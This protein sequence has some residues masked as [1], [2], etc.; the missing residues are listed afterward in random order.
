MG[1]VATLVI[2]QSAQSLTLAAWLGFAAGAFA[3]VAAAAYFDDVTITDLAEPAPGIV[4]LTTHA[5][6]NGVTADWAVA[7]G[8]GGVRAASWTATAFAQPPF[9]PQPQG[10]T[11]LPGFA[12]TYSSLPDGSL[13]MN[14]P[15]L[16]AF[17]AQP[18]IYTEGETSDEFLIRV[19]IGDAT[20]APDIGED[21]GVDRVDFY[22]W[23][24]DITLDNYEQM[25]RWGLGKG[26][27]S[28]IGYVY[29]DS[30]LSAACIA[31]VLISETF[32]IHISSNVVL[33]LEQ[34]GYHYP[35]E[36]DAFNNVIG[37]ELFHNFQMAY[38][39][40]EQTGRNPHFSYVEGT[41]R[42]QETLHSY[43]A[44]SHQ[45]QSLV[46][47]RN[48][49]GCPGWLGSNANQAFANG[50]FEGHSYDACYFWMT[51]FDTHG[52]EGLVRLVEAIHD[53]VGESSGAPQIFPAIEDATGGTLA[54]DLAIFA[55]NAITKRGYVWPAGDDGEELD[56]ARFLPTLGPQRLDVG[57]S[58][59]ATL[60]NGGLMAAEVRNAGV[61]GLD[62]P[63]AVVL[64]LVTD[65]GEETVHERIEPGLIEAPE[66]GER[67][68]VVAVHPAV[69]QAAVTLTLTAA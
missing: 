15:M 32:N 7:V 58:R 62:A 61:L 12:R 37:H 20:I 54:D 33:I 9:D 47:A 13:R 2:S 43:S 57:D 63:E 17:D 48:I 3:G 68:W 26:W 39:K 21:T 56:W 6:T 28:D 29:V 18:S 53:H 40:P 16:P 1:V 22:R 59:S 11:A 65:D 8:A 5:R 50:L 19:S 36:R 45:P 30:A 25:H 67:Q 23:V 34:L 31:C 27:T 51:W 69:G 35:D 55:G 38:W 49:N 10:L 66:P 41:A 44:V 42:F 46:Y 64:Y 14:Q 4:S 52:H 60:R 24:R